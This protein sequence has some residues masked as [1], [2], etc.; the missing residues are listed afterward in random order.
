MSLTLQHP[1]LERLAKD[2][3]KRTGQKLEQAVLTALQ[4]KLERLTPLSERLSLAAESLKE[5]YEQDTQLT[6]FTILDGEPLH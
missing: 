5:D 3:A 4:E 6:A 2:V 1:D